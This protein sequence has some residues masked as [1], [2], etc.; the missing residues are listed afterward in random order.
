MKISNSASNA[1]ATFQITGSNLGTYYW[2]IFGNTRLATGIGQ[3]GNTLV[4][5]AS[6]TS[7]EMVANVGS[8]LKVLDATTTINIQLNSGNVLHTATMDDVEVD[9]VYIEVFKED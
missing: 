9:V 5:T 6:T 8:T 2:E 1:F 7:I 3:T 4:S